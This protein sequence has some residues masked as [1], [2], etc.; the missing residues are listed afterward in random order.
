MTIL[1][2]VISG[3]HICPKTAFIIISSEEQYCPSAT[4]HYQKLYI[5]LY[6][7]LRDFNIIRDR[8]QNNTSYV[9]EIKKLYYMDLFANPN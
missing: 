7:Y 1:T 2:F 8:K 9:F 4:L 6:A 3:D 5:S